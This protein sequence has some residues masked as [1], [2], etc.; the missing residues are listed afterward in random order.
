MLYFKDINVELINLVIASIIL[1]VV[2]ILLNN[3][4][5]EKHYFR[6]MIDLSGPLISYYNKGKIDNQTLYLT[7]LDL[8][9]KGF[10]KIE[11][12]EDKLVLKWQKGS[13]FDVD[14]YELKSTEKILAKYI[15][16]ILFEY[17]NATLEQLGELIKSNLNF[18]NMINK[19]YDDFKYEIKHSYGYIRKENNYFLAILLTLIYTISVFNISSL[20]GI[21]IGGIYTFLVIILGLVLKN[22][23]LSLKGFFNVFLLIYIVLMSITPIFP[24]FTVNGILP[25]LAIFNPI[26]FIV[27]AYILNLRFYTPKQKELMFKIE[28][29]KN[30]LNDFSNMDKRSV[31]YIN[32]FNKYYAYAVALDIKLDDMYQGMEYD[33]NSLNTLTSLELVNGLSNLFYKPTGKSIYD[34][35]FSSKR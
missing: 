30:F 31:E 32:L 10:Y 22:F 16:S 13:L 3:N 18:N 1:L 34:T 25:T 2:F 23:T 17:Q 24:T 6:D 5:K 9:S 14:K 19:F 26:L 21:F 7:L 12:V 15:N 8:I 29:M 11:R 28:G 33:D 20:S 27:I 4:K 35:S